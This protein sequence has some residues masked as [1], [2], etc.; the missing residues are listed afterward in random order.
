MKRGPCMFRQ[1]DVTRAIRAVFAA[2]A[3]RAE[4]RVGDIVI[5]AEKTAA[6]DVRVETVN[7]WDT[8]HGESG[9]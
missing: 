6:G 8:P 9:K 2:G 3:L 1:R 4:I 7:E 5:A